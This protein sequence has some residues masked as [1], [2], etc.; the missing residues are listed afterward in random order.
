MFNII[1]T[2]VG[3]VIDTFATLAEAEATLEKFV[4]S[5]KADGIYE[6]NFYSI[7]EVDVE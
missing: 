5:D 1:N 4:D 7:V 6:E 2:E 3:T